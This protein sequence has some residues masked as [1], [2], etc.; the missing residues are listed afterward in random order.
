[1]KI[2]GSGRGYPMYLADAVSNSIKALF[3]FLNIAVPGP[4]TGKIEHKT[5]ELV[6]WSGIFKIARFVAASQGQSC[7][8]ENFVV[9][10]KCKVNR[11]LI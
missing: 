6:A 1:M 8:I 2:Q 11:Q 9:S 7:R 10:M 3:L 5:P 4:M